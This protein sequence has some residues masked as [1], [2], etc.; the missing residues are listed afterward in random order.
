MFCFLYVLQLL[1]IPILETIE[2]FRLVQKDHVTIA[3]FFR[4]LSPDY[5]F[6]NESID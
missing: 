1:Y 5:P 2:Q 6:S 4:S 3:G